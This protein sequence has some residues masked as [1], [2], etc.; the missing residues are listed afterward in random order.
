MVDILIY[1]VFLLYN[2]N[3]V[4]SSF[5]C[6]QVCSGWLSPEVN[7]VY[8]VYDE[9]ENQTLMFSCITHSTV[10]HTGLNNVST[11]KPKRFEHIFVT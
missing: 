10:S 11:R 2:V 8:D 1:A 9:Y 5:N 7:S 3:D 4:H 6:M